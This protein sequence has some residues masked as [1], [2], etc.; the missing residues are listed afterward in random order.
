MRNRLLR[1]YGLIEREVL[2]I[3]QL[4]RSICLKFLSQLLIK[5]MIRLAGLQVL[6]IVGVLTTPTT[7]TKQEKFKF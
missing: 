1:L 6:P 4:V 3:Y 5:I 7:L 2:A